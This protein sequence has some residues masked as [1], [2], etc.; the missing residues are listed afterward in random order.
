MDDKAF[1]V[2][3][4]KIK[5]MAKNLKTGAETKLVDPPEVEVELGAAE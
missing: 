3:R 4:E 2:I 1:E 5:K